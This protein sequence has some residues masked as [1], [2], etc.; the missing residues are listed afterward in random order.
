MKDFLD[1]AS[2]AYYEGT[3]VISDAEFDILSSHFDYKSVGHTIT[4]G[5]PHF[6]RMYSL[7]NCFDLDKAP[8]SIDLCVKTPKLDGAAISILYIGGELSLALTRGDGRIGRDI[9]DKVATLVPNTIKREGI[10][11]I[12]GEVL[13]PKN[14]ENSRN[15]AAGS[16]GLKGT[17]EFKTRPLVF[18]AYDVSDNPFPLY[19]EMME[20]LPYMG[21]N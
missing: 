16:L 3:P 11:Q 2:K 4:G 9:T 8:L 19:I 17:E 21:F 7:Q 14:I 6:H 10:V 18:V 5:V 1:R 12:T 15:Y 20:V 13:A